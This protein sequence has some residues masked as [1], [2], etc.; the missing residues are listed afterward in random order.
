MNLKGRAAYTSQ[1]KVGNGACRV[2][3][4]NHPLGSLECSVPAGGARWAA[5]CKV[6]SSRVKWLMRARCSAVVTIWLLRAV[7]MWF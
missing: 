7:A 4:A 3:D 6:Q 1:K 5:K 2:E